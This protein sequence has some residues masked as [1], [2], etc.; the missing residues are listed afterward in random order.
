MSEEV[1]M[2][3]RIDISEYTNGLCY[4]LGLETSFVREMRITPTTVTATLYKPNENGAKYID[5]ESNEA[6]VEEREFKVTT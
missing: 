3:D 4:A 6:A 1:E 2:N 5:P